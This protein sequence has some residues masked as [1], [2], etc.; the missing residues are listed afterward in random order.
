MPD[1]RWTPEE[2]RE[3]AA[4]GIGKVDLGPRW[5]ERVTHDEIAAMAAVAAMSGLTPI[6]PKKHGENP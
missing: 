2:M 1:E 6:Y 3:L 5:I 4:R